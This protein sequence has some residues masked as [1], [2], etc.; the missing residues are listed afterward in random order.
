M[1]RMLCR[2]AAAAMTLVMLSG[3]ASGEVA[4]TQSAS[5]SS[6][7]EDAVVLAQSDAMA[8]EDIQEEAVAL[9]DSPS[10]VPLNLTPKATGTVVKKNSKA[11]VDYS[12]VADGYVMVQYTASTSKKL[13]AR[14]KGP[15]GVIYT[16]NL[17][18]GEWAVFS[19][20]DGS[21]SYQVTVYE[22]ISGTKY[23]TV[24]SAD[25]T[26]TLENEF[27]PFLLPNQY[28]DYTDAP[29]TLKK[30][31]E[32][33]KGITDPLEKVKA[34]YTFVVK[35]L[36]YDK[37]KASTV[38]SGYLPVLDTVL[39]EK[40]GICFDYAALMAGMLRSQD[41]PCKLVVGYSGTVYHAWINV[42]SEKSGWING[43]IF[44][45][46]TTWKLMDPTFASTGKQ[47]ASIMK[48]I[49]DGSNYS[50]KYIY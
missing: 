36:T 22:N 27:L 29:N 43:V 3:C 44:F 17:T 12:N 32:L 33:T 10:A 31:Q 1:K 4:E 41:V 48:Y 28:V 15:S 24:L 8:Q 2:L 30:A 16:Y 47:S 42:Y 21:G 40:K 14:V 35:N 46:G 25:F 34:V 19:L 11:V 13:K 38:T 6:A 39:A 9:G 45:D 23:A 26:A 50:A 20:S 5:Q 37:A 18:A 49:G 7:V